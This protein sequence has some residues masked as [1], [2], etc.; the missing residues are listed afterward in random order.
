MVLVSNSIN[1]RLYTIEKAIA[2]L[3]A[4]IITDTNLISIIINAILT[5]NVPVNLANQFIDGLIAIS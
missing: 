2:T 3:K 5:L 1:K 4:T